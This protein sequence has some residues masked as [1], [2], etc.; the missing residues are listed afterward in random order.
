[1]SR[2]TDN[3]Q[4]TDDATVRLASWRPD[5]CK[6]PA[7]TDA[8]VGETPQTSLKNTDRVSDFRL[9]S[10]HASKRSFGAFELSKTPISLSTQASV[11]CADFVLAQFEFQTPR[12]SAPTA[13]ASGAVSVWGRHYSTGTPGSDRAVKCE[14]AAAG[15]GRDTSPGACHGGRQLGRTAVCRA[16]RQFYSRPRLGAQ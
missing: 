12:Q 11:V 2:R 3:A 14:V 9:S 8:T 1:M 4:R 5:G 13:T 7:P 16:G 10:F 15:G 6:H